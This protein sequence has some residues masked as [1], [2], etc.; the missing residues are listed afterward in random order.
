MAFL[1]FFI[2]P[3]FASDFGATE[4]IC[5]FAEKDAEL[6]IATL[7]SATNQVNQNIDER[8]RTTHAVL[9]RIERSRINQ[10]I[11]DRKRSKEY[12]RELDERLANNVI[13]VKSQN[14]R[15]ALCER[16]RRPGASKI[17]IAT[18]TYSRCRDI[19]LKLKSETHGLCF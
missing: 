14:Y 8:I 12:D 1:I 19:L 7:D 6:A 15:F 11:E 18:D 2:C 10:V 17:T 3:S 9:L 16:K 5:G 13:N 4:T